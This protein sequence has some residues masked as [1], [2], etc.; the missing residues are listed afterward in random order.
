MLIG[1]LK[2]RVYWANDKSR[3]STTASWKAG[4]SHPHALKVLGFREALTHDWRQDTGPDAEIWLYPIASQNGPVLRP[5]RVN[6]KLNTDIIERE[7]GITLY[8][9]GIFIDLDDEPS[10]AEPHLRTGQGWFERVETALEPFR[11][12]QGCF[13]YRTLRGARIGIIFETPVSIDLGDRARRV[14]FHQLQK[15]F[16]DD[17]T[18]DV[19]QG[20]TEI[21]RGFAA[22]LIYKK[23]E[24]IEDDLPQFYIHD[25]DMPVDNIEALAGMWSKVLQ[26]IGNS[27]QADSE[28]RSED[29]PSATAP[30]G[31]EDQASRTPKGNKKQKVFVPANFDPDEIEGDVAYKLYNDLSTKLGGQITQYRPLLHDLIR[32]IDKHVS[33]GR[34]EASGQ[35]DAMVDSVLGYVEP[36]EIDLP[37]APVTLPDFPDLAP[38]RRMFSYPRDD[39]SIAQAVLDSMGVEPPPIWHGDGLR[40]YSSG[41]GTWKIYRKP[42]LEQILTKL[43][44][45]QVESAKG[46][47]S[48]LPINMKL[49]N[50]SINMLMSL[51]DSGESE[52]PFD[53]APEGVVLGDRF[54]SATST[55]L[56]VSPLSPD[57]YAIHNLDYPLS[58]DLLNYWDD[59]DT[60][61]E[62]RRPKI[63]TNTFLK[64]SLHREPDED[65][66][67]YT[68]EAEIDAKITTVGEW[69]GLALLGL[70]TREATALV[71]FGEGSNGK[72]VLASLLSDLFGAE[73]TAHLAPQ[74]MK[75]RFSR[76]QLF[77]AVINVV[78]EM[79]ETDLLESDTLKAMISGDA[80]TVEHKGEKPFR[81]RPKAAHFFAA[82]KLPAS[83]DRSHGLWRRLVPIEFHH[84][85]TRS[86]RDPD[87]LD[88]LRSEYHLL[89]PWALD[90]ARQ[91]IERGGYAHQDYIDRW[92]G[93]W[94]IETDALSAFISLQCE[95]TH[96]GELMTVKKLWQAFRVWAEEVGQS[97][98]AKMSLNAFSR[99]LSAQPNIKKYR[100]R[101][102]DSARSSS[103]VTHFNLKTIDIN[104][105]FNNGKNNTS[106]TRTA[107]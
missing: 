103:A 95:V 4:E 94:R 55:G 35:I 19:D 82:N 23:G 40:R 17:S 33:G 41:T 81:M 13:Y 74:A 30:K 26:E 28:R 15:T 75:E 20:S 32:M 10:H 98:A 7:L 43:E 2:T 105:E 100:R 84:I 76:A 56:R 78:S 97:G 24:R 72:S 107:H 93:V 47:L 48:Q 36:V 22:P 67:V 69:T 42:Q 1:A 14:F 52:T 29:A 31:D 8:T 57:H 91:Y 65:E 83:R 63:F 9:S 87:L 80:I 58:P 101:E 37:P 25:Q 54:V 59:E 106:P 86:D 39:L 18:V 102:K 21:T 38:L 79:P 62:P 3:Y 11:S 6:R 46:D 71:C 89:V 61:Q 73:R 60:G 92:I 50:S 88:K 53:T 34:R 96:D 64:R 44:G 5:R 90:L 16:S 51:T 70:C 77:G 45:A 99:A 104:D 66:T 12:L 85:F 68:I 27:A 49:I